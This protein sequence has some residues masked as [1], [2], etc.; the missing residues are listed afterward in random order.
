MI[1]S[2]APRPRPTILSRPSSGAHDGTVRP[3]EK[4]LR[5]LAWA[6]RP[7]P[8]PAVDARSF[9]PAPPEAALYR[10]GLWLPWR[11]PCRAQWVSVSLCSMAIVTAGVL[12]G[13]PYRALG[14]HPRG[15]GG[16]D[17]DGWPPR[18]HVAGRSRPREGLGLPPH[19]VEKGLLLSTAA[20]R[21]GI[22][23]PLWPLR[24]ASPGSRYL[25]GG[26]AAAACGRSVGV[27][28]PHH[29]RHAGLDLSAAAG[30]GAAVAG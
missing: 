12:E 26:L 11:G 9:L 30:H 6:E 2:P 10:L 5:C 28:P 25:L 7:P 13:G 15:C 20:Q 21:S 27:P 24:S 19:T 23:P 18:A 29:G 8:A 14:S 16:V 1:S 3:G 22:S 4:P 17:G